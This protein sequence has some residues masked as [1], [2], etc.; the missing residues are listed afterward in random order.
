MTV[1]PARLRRTRDKT[2]VYRRFRGPGPLTYIGL[3][4]IALLSL[5]PLY[6]SFVVASHDTASAS[7]YP[8]VLTPGTQLFHNI[9]QLKGSYFASTRGMGTHNLTAGYQ[10]YQDM[11]KANNRQSASDYTIYCMTTRTAPPTVRCW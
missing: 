2:H 3:T 1:V 6:W 5:F 7:S 4:V 8:P 9:G 11:L 10:I